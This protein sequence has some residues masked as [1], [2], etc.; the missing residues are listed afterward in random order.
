M[1]RTNEGETILRQIEKDGKI[2]SIKKLSRL[3]KIAKKIGDFTY[4]RMVEVQA[5][6]KSQ[7]EKSMQEEGR[8]F[9]LSKEGG[10]E[11]L[12]SKLKLRK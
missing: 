2:D 4:H 9:L 5:Y 12:E 1:I 6:D 7:D 3:F 11:S 8:I 10:Q